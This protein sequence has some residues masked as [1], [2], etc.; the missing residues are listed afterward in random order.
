[1]C[2]MVQNVQHSNGPPNHV[3]RSFDNWTKSVWKVKFL[4][5]RCLVHKWCLYWIDYSGIQTVETSLV[6]FL[7]ISFVSGHL[8][9]KLHLKAGRFSPKMFNSFWQPYGFFWK[10]NKMSS[11]QMAL[12]NQT[13]WFLNWGQLF[14]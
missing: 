4:N 11:F 2:F 8:K 12:E 7:N 6:T 9:T 3:I 5:F 1:M 10:P 13:I 14:E